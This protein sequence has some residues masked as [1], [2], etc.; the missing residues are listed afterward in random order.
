MPL[1]PNALAIRLGNL[2]MNHR[3]APWNQPRGAHRQLAPE[4][5][6]VFD[7]FDEIRKSATMPQPPAEPQTLRNAVLFLAE[8][9]EEDPAQIA[10][11]PEIR[12]KAFRRA[13]LKLHPDQG[14]DATLYRQLTAYNQ[15]LEWANN[16]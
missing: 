2:L 1:D 6:I 16:K 9:G 4:I 7:L 12:R 14:G 15:I 10:S 13:A 5:E 11:N 8:H 3:R